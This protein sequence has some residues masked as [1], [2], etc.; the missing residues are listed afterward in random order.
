MLRLFNCESKVIVLKKLNARGQKI[1]SNE[2]FCNVQSPP[3]LVRIKHTRNL[4]CFPVVLVLNSQAHM[5]PCVESLHTRVTVAKRGT[6]IIFNMNNLLKIVVIFCTLDRNLAFF[7]KY[8]NLI[9]K[10]YFLI[11][12]YQNS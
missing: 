11:C 3:K 5:A 8:N 12:S 6:W 2:G 7:K 10:T 4:R 9:M 1:G